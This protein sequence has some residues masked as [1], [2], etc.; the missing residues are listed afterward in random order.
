VLGLELGLLSNTALSSGRP[1]EN[2]RGWQ[3][4]A[5]WQWPVSGGLIRSQMNY[6]RLRDQA[7]YSPLLANGADRWLERSY[8]LLQYQRPIQPGLMFLTRFYHQYQRSNIALFDTRDSSLE[9][10]LGFAF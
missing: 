6:T 3:V 10:G 1:G 4:S 9:I 2:R 7:G 5:D 8:V